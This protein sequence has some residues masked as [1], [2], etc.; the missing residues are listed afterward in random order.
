MPKRTQEKQEMAVADPLKE[1]NGCHKCRS[2][3]VASFPV[4]LVERDGNICIIGRVVRCAKC[5]FVKRYGSILGIYKPTSGA[6]DTNVA[7]WPEIL[8]NNID[9]EKFDTAID[10]APKGMIWL[11][12]RKMQR[13]Y[14]SRERAPFYEAR[15][16]ND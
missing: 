5:G 3:S 4:H 7:R 12:A 14:S 9:V 16:R 13:A 15:G 1:P 10:N 6:P 8:R 11:D 2:F